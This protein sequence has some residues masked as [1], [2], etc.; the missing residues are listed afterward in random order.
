MRFACFPFNH[1]FWSLC[2]IW[3]LVTSCVWFRFA[4]ISCVFKRLHVICICE[5]FLFYMLSQHTVKIRCILWDCNCLPRL[6]EMEYNYMVFFALYVTSFCAKSVILQVFGKELNVAVSS[7]FCHR[8]FPLATQVNTQVNEVFKE[9]C[10]RFGTVSLNVFPLELSSICRN[11]LSYLVWPS[12]CPLVW[13]IAF[14]HQTRAEFIPR[15][16]LQTFFWK[17]KKHFNW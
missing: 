6:G 11:D 16:N 5:Y 13:C 14:S 3:Q 4:H 8:F 17:K 10:E 2:F 7:H 12:F 1:F 9:P 15:C